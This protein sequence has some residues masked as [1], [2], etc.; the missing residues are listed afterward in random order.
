KAATVGRMT[1]TELPE[2]EVLERPREQRASITSHPAVQ[3]FAPLVL[4]AV[5]AAVW[6]GRGVIAHPTTRTLG[7]AD[8]DKTILMWSFLWWPHAIAHGHDP[9]VAN[10]VWSPHGVDLSWVTSSPT[11]ALA[12][13]PFTAM[14]G[15]VFSYNLAAL[16]APPLAAW[17]TFL[18]ARHL[19]RNLP[20]SLVAGFLFGF[21]PY[22]I[23]QSVT[24]LNLSFICL[25]PVAG[26][27]AV[28]FFEGSLSARW[29]TG[30]LALILVLQFGIS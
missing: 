13:A 30:L 12:L 24:H 9:F 14:F 2:T 19:T 22:V 6:I 25:L 20:A 23:S 27:L 28:R 7:N 17:T 26:L 3:T 29:Y 15:A 5:F 16:A 18:L 4:Y 1:E 21:S 11:L 8:R 10:V